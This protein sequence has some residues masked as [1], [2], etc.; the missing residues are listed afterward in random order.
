MEINH[1]Q[2]PLYRIPR[3]KKGDRVRI[4]P[5]EPTP[6]A[7]LPAVVQEV[8]PDARNVTPLDRYV[9]VFAWGERQAFY[10]A[11]LLKDRTRT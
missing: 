5:A 10:D 3:F 11:Q 2:D 6:F 8:E 4:R 7:G 1:N 9:V